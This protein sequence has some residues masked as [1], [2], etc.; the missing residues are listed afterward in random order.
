MCEPDVYEARNK[1]QFSLV[2][3][4]YTEPPPVDIN[5]LLIAAPCQRGTFATLMCWV[6]CVS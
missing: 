6:C 5:L 4:I 1:P 3:L 2:M